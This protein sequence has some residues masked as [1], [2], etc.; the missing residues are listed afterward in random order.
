M[1]VVDFARL[2]KQILTESIVNLNFQGYIMQRFITFHLGRYRQRTAEAA[3]A[4]A[5]ANK[6][7]TDKKAK[8]AK[9]LEK[10]AKD[11]QSELSEADQNTK[12]RK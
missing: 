4:L 5:E 2:L 12:K 1:A 9:E 6:A 8:K 11:E 7:K 10:S 3:A